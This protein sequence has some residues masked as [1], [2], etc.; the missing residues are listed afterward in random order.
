[1][2]PNRRPSSNPSQPI[3]VGQQPGQQV[4]LAVPDCAQPAQVVDA[5]VVEPQPVDRHAKRGGDPPAHVGRSVA[6]ADH[7]ISEHPLQRLGDQAGGVG[8]VDEQGIRRVPGDLLG[9]GGGR[10]HRA[11]G[12]RDAAGAGRFLADRTGLHCDPLVQQS[13]LEAAHADGAVDD[14][15]ALERVAQIAGAAVGDAVAKLG[16]I[17]ASTAPICCSRSV[18]GSN[19]TTSS[20]RIVPASVT[21]AR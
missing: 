9:D 13:A 16:S 17:P 14:V 10:R 19:S 2:P 15:G 7:A 18:S 3:V 12:E 6:D 20:K 11:Q 8:E 5:E 1:M 21:S 4:V